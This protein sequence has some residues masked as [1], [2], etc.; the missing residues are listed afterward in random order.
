M[1]TYTSLP[2]KYRP[3]K[4]SD[5]AGQ[6][7]SINRLKGI[8]ESGKIPQ[9]IMFVGPTG[10][11]K[12]TLARMFASY[13]NCKTNDLCGECPSCLA[14]ESNI[15]IKELNGGEAR[16]I[17][18][19]RD[20][21]SEANFMPTIGK[22]RFIILDEMQQLTSQAAQCLLKP[23]EEPP[24]HTIYI[25]CSMEPDKILPAIVGRCSKFQLHLP[26]REEIA[27]RIKKIAKKEKVD[28]ISSKAA[29][30]I[31][32]ASGGQV[33]D[34]VS[35]LESV[36]Q[37]VDGAKETKDIDKL[38][39]E[40][41]QAAAEL[42]DD[43]VA[44][45]VLLSV[46][47]GNAGSTHSSILDA[48]NFNSLSQKLTYLNLFIMDHVF[49]DGHQKVFYTAANRKFLDNCKAKISDMKEMAPIFVKVQKALNEIKMQM[50]T[51]LATDRA[52]FSAQLT[53]L[54]Y[55]IKAERKK[56]K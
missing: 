6:K 29:L 23:I 50:G 17:D 53:S 27:E 45:K 30:N 39:G 33:R 13:I 10:T 26:E 38:V 54:A 40:A 8:V 46:Y 9:A 35:L 42:G 31:A 52:I 25:L 2:V 5:V 47:L 19:I 15:D 34:A 22:Y 49:A 20:L 36:I 11:G 28:Y 24:S 7:T 56:A 37:Y 41:I 1:A 55:D 18:D 12:T 4:W 43:L 44:M 51:F 16:G 32:E 3:R 14:G 48:N 21:I